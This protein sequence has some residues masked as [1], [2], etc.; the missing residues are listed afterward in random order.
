MAETHTF[1][2]YPKYLGKVNGQ[3]VIASDAVE[4]IS[5]REKFFSKPEE[6]T[7]ATVSKVKK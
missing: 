7:P 5:L 1:R 6:K 2:E 4:E 3:D